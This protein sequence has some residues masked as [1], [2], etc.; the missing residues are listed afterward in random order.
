MSFVY[1]YLWIIM[2]KLTEIC[3]SL[4]ADRLVALDKEFAAK[5]KIPDLTPAEIQQ[6]VQQFKILPSEKRRQIV[7]AIQRPCAYCEKEFKLPT[8]GKS[9]GICLRHFEEQFKAMG[10]KAP[11]KN[12]KD[13]SA[14]LKELS[15]A[16]RKLVVNLFAISR[17]RK[18]N[19]SPAK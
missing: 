5:P 1:I 12:V 10:M 14:D 6:T 18:Q 19:P 15:D 9:H 17:K 3:E 7:R 11:T 13:A 16:E 4:G 2:I 8:T